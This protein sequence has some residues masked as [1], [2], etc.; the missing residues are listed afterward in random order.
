MYPYITFLNKSISTYG[1]LMFFGIALV[2]ILAFRRAKKHHVSIDDMLIIAAFSLLIGLV[3]ASLLYA[4]ASYPISVIIKSIFTGKF[5]IFGG[6]VYYGGLIGGIIGGI[7]GVKVT[8]VKTQIAEMAIIPFLPIGHAIGR[9]GCVMAG[10][11]N[12]MKYDGILAIYY[13]NSITGL[14]AEHG[15]FPVQFLEAALNIVIAVFLINYSKKEKPKYNILFLYLLIYAIIR[16]S[17]EFLRGDKIRGI[18]FGL[19]T[20][21]WIS[22]LLFIISVF[23][24]CILYC[25]LRKSKE[26][27]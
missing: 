11:C 5:E 23:Y 1:I 4:F 10:C 9:V 26:S 2:F 24:F 6:I 7:I 25:K 20:S 17:L 19:S 27:W 13:R 16:F 18:Y 15:Y 8:K 14:S 3:G 21:Q 12:G 22:I